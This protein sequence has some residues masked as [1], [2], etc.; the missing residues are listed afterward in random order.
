M[1]WCNHTN[2]DWND[3]INI[4]NIL[5]KE[6]TNDALGLSNVAFVPT[7]SDKILAPSI[8][9]PETY[10]VW[11]RHII[12]TRLSMW[13]KKNCEIITNLKNVTLSHFITNWKF[14]QAN[15]WEF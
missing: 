10:F 4:T 1:T 7:S 12:H 9:I 5:S 3:I 11:L 15:K 2:R 6:A 14:K 8:S 13:R